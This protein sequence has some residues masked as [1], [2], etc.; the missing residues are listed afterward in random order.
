VANPVIAT[1][2]CKQGCFESIE[3]F[4]VRT[5]IDDVSDKVLGRIFEPKDKK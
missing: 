1:E 3:Y 5:E 2:Y 4:G